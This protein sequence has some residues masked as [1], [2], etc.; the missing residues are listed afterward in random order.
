MAATPNFNTLADV[1]TWL[2]T[3]ATGDAVQIGS[4][5]FAPA[6]AAQMFRMLP[7][8]DPLVLTFS[9]TATKE[10]TATLSGTGT[11][12]G[13]ACTVKLSFSADADDPLLV[14]I[15]VDRP[16]DAIWRPVSGFDF[17]FGGLTATI[18]PDPDVGAASFVFTGNLVVDG[19]PELVAQL[20]LPAVPDLDWTLAVA[21]TTK[22]SQNLLSKLAGGTN[23]LTVIGNG[24]SLDH[25]TL[26]GFNMAFSPSGGVSMFRIGLAY[27]SNWQPFGTDVFEVTGFDFAFEGHKPFDAN[28]FQALATA[29]TKIDDV[30]IDVS[31]QFPDAAIFAYLDA[32]ASLS[33]TKV[34]TGFH[35]PLPQ[36]FPDIEISALSFGIY[37]L[38]RAIDF[39]LGIDK[40]VPITESIVFDAFHFDLGI[41]YQSGSFSGHGDLFA[42]FSFG[43]TNPTIVALTGS[44]DSSGALALAGSVA[45]LE[46]GHVIEA[47]V[48]Q[49]GVDRSK[50]PGAIDKLVLDTLTVSFSRDATSTQFHFLCSGHTQ[51]ADEQVKFAP[52]LNVTYDANSKNWLLDVGGTLD[53]IDDQGT[54]EFAVEFVKSSTDTSVTATYSSADP[55]SFKRIAHVFGFDISGVPPELDLDLVGLGISYDFTIGNLV[56]GARSSNPHYGSAVFLSQSGNPRQNIFLLKTANSLSLAQLPLVGSELAKIG[57][58]ALTD[59]AAAIALP[60][61]VGPGAVAALNQSIGKIGAQYPLVPAAGLP[62]RLVLAATLKLGGSAPQPL[63]I[64]LLAPAPTPTP[65]PSPTLPALAAAGADDGT[66]WVQVQKSFGPVS[67]Q[68]VGVRYADGKIWALMN[69]ELQAGPVDFSVIGLG[70]GSPLTSFDPN[71][72][73]DGITLAINAGP[74]AFSGALVGTLSPVNLYGALA[75]TL[76]GFSIGAIGGYAEYQG[77]PSCFIY[78]VLGGEL[79]GP[80]FFFVTGIAAGFGFNRTLL[81]PPVGQLNQFPLIAWAVGTGPS[82]TPGGDVGGQV[83]NAMD[84]LAQSGVIAPA[85][86]EYW[87]AAGVQ[88]TSFKLLNSF[89]LLTVKLGNEVEVDVL[90]LSTLTLPPE[91]TKP[92]AV[93]QLALEASF[94]PA[95]KE[96][97]VTGQLTSASFVLSPDCRLTGGFAFCM[98]Y[99]PPH[100][101]DFVVTLGGYSPRFNK[102]SHYP[103]VPRLGLNWQIGPLTISGD[104]YFALTPS[105]VMAGGG[106]KAVW[107]SG[108]IRA[109]FSAEVDFLLLFNPVHYYIRAAIELGASVT[110]DLWFTSFTISIHLGVD[111]EI[112]G[113]KFA[114]AIHVDLDIVSFTIQFGD[115]SRDPPK[116]LEWDDFVEQVLPSRPP[117]AAPVR[118]AR[119]ALLAAAPLTQG[120]P[121]TLVQINAPT[122]ILQT[123]PPVAGATLPLDWLVDGELLALTV[124]SKVPLREAASL[125]DD[126]NVTLA[127]DPNDHG[128]PNFTIG[129]G[130]AG[131]KPDDL[132]AT[133]TIKASAQVDEGAVIYATQMLDA[134]PKAVWEHRELDS[135]GVPA[136]VDPMNDTLVAD[137]LTG[138]RLVPQTPTPQASLEIPIRYLAYTND[139]AQ[140]AVAWSTPVVSANDPFTDQTVHDTIADPIATANR[141]TLIAAINQAGFAVD[142]QIDVSTLADATSGALLWPPQL[143]YLGEAR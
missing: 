133:L 132:A 109:W 27:H 97:S 138:Y 31:V 54:M 10:G 44:Y 40:P 30:P 113:P 2:A 60:A 114:G 25:F 16:A 41:E 3:L 55:L 78:A 115:E 119:T 64:S 37:A 34:F 21:G 9:G 108:A 143:R 33:L 58:V 135:N 11:V 8:S 22:P 36:G 6:I 98:W 96:I 116:P 46:I 35:I 43:A 19:E 100:A 81:I 51:I 88:F 66:K 104:E 90:G 13:E 120:P 140:I 59:L 49:F 110:I 126:G 91:T 75:L 92:I 136:G 105:A 87:I 29:K 24:F 1:E 61:P 83:R 107:S 80:P 38:Q 39:T 72:T 131:M 32:S 52:F 18:A 142:P 42:Q 122:G 48:A 62:G 101:G 93:A 65:S 14:T 56:I 137:A 86:G 130:P 12:L 84:Q 103:D 139:G 121:D 63:S 28:S 5:N 77:H 76:P 45:N 4:A 70:I 124:I 20:A 134:V 99:G 47:L 117:A 74:V 123:L 79:G 23:P 17:G 67:I 106:L 82:S 95:R 15:E 89:A 118:Q 53:L 102:P 50:V 129:V 94:A 112:W 127:A 141:A 57:D 7:G 125:T 85:I 111:T 69:A 73:V 68:K 71:F 128:Q 26:S